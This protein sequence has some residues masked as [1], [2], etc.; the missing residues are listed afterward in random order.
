M[1]GGLA[2][3]LKLDSRL[4]YGYSKSHLV[5]PTGRGECAG[6][7]NDVRYEGR[8]IFTEEGSVYGE[9]KYIFSACT[10]DSNNGHSRYDATADFRMGQK[11]AVYTT[12]IYGYGNNFIWVHTGYANW[13]GNDWFG[14]NGLNYITSI[15]PQQ[16]T[17]IED[18]DNTIALFT[19]YG[20]DTEHWSFETMSYPKM[21]NMPEIDEEV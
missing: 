2:N 17:F 7:T 4:Y 12:R 21:L 3:D 19:S 11:N 1:L 6:V 18:A 15:T 20:F 9:F 16:A 14:I 13:D 8:T 10:F 5:D